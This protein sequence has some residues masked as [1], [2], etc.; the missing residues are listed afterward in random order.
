MIPSVHV[1]PDNDH[2]MSDLLPIWSVTF[3]TA[4]VLITFS[5]GSTLKLTHCIVYCTLLQQSVREH[6]PDSL[7]CL[8]MTEC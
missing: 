6:L 1:P 4:Y 7:F 2:L 3:D 8:T 5:E